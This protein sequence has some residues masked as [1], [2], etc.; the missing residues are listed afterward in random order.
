MKTK[1]KHTPNPRTVYPVG[2][3]N[4]ETAP[5]LEVVTTDGKTISSYNTRINENALADALL[6]AA[7]P[8]LLENLRY[9][10]YAFDG[11]VKNGIA[12]GPKGA[13]H[14]TLARLQA[15][16]ARAEGR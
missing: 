2:T 10:A 13:D 6:H 11:W 15:V 9:V 5:E 7:A 4:I 14:E 3:D 12:T 1:T 16:I 8:E